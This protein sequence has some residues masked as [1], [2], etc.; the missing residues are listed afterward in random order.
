MKKRIRK[1]YLSEEEQRVLMLYNECEKVEFTRYHVETKA[2][3]AFVSILGKP[4]IDENNDVIWYSA[5]KGKVEVTA[6]LRRDQ[7]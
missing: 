7:E 6:F 3:K 1:K 5:T 2:A 4:Q